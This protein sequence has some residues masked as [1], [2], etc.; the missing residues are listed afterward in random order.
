MIKNTRNQVYT[1]E[2]KDG[3]EKDGFLQ[4]DLEAHCIGIVEVGGQMEIIYSPSLVA[5]RN[6]TTKLLWQPY[7][8]NY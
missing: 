7:G 8:N 4:S 5:R 6:L 1:S 2:G 3:T